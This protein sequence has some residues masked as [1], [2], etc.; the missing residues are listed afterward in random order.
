MVAYYYPP[1]AA[2]GSHRVMH[3]SR[4]LGKLGWKVDVIT[5]SDF[6]RNA[7]D[8]DLVE[9][10]GGTVGIR[11][12]PT[13]DFV[14]LLA[15]MKASLRRLT[16]SGGNGQE[17]D[18]GANQNDRRNA[19]VERTGVFD[20]I[21]RFMKTPDSMLTFIPGVVLGALPLMMGRRPDVIYSSAPP[22]SCHL[23]AYCLKQLFRVP[24]LADF[25]DPWTENPFRNDNPYR[26]LQV[27]NNNLE[28]MVVRE[29]DVVVANTPALEAAFRD[30]YPHYDHFVTLTNGFDPRILTQTPPSQNSD[31]MT[32]AGSGAFKLVHTGEVY[33]LRSPHSL[34]IAMGDLCRED[35]AWPSRFQ[36]HFYGKVEEEEMLRT[37]ARAMGVETAF[38]YEGT[39]THQAALNA[40]SQADGLL[41]LGVKGSRLEVQVPSKLFEYLAIRKPIVSLSKRGGAI[42][43]ILQESGVP[44]LLADLENPEEVK[45]VLKRAVKGDFDGGVGWEGIKAFAFDRL[46]FRLSE[47]LMRLKKRMAPRE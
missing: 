39:V 45:T 4:E 13:T 44:Y 24:W 18:A 32:V 29:A 25:R 27:L 38:S 30:R 22:Y 19:G 47:L 7:V 20:Y 34:I 21:S 6:K 28:R 11:R 42:H 9:R 36:T 10:L 16:A 46:T 2:A 40:C 23:A 33:G 31:S 5:S 35:P 17:F 15:R 41:L 37:Q 8:H 14:E 43:G 3:F 1:M 26:S 12:V